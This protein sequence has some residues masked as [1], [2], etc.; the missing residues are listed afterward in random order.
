MLIRDLTNLI[1]KEVDRT[2]GLVAARGL[3]KKMSEEKRQK[4]KEGV[5]SKIVSLILQTR[6]FEEDVESMSITAFISED[7]LN[8]IVTTTMVESFSIF[9]NNK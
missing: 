6:H 7:I 4:V 1:T 9:E 8:E 3:Y 2:M 5:E